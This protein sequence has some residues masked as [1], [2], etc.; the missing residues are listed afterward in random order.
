VVIGS[1]ELDFFYHSCKIKAPPIYKPHCTCL[2]PGGFFLVIHNIMFLRCI[3]DV[4]IGLLL[5]LAL[6]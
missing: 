5:T 2:S 3:P 6:N 1:F 4:C